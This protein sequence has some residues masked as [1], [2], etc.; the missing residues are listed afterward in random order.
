VEAEEIAFVSLRDSVDR[1]FHHMAEQK[2][3]GFR[4][5]I[6]PRLPRTFTTD[7]KRLQQILKNLL[8]N[9]FKFTAQG[10]VAMRVAPVSSGWSSE[11]PILQHAQ[12]AIAIEVSDTGIGIAPE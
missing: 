5:E 8:S 4:I 1:M 12:Q 10:H 7:P 3:L 9:A 6:D 2:N 11:H